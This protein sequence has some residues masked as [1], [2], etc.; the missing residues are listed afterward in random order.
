MDDAVEAFV[1]FVAEAV[2]GYHDP[3]VAE[4]GL[5][6]HPVADPD[7]GLL[8]LVGGGRVDKVAALVFVEVEDLEDGFLVHCS[9]HRSPAYG[10]LVLRIVRGNRS[11]LLLPYQ[12]SPKFIMP[13]ARGL[14]LI[15]AEG[16]SKRYLP[17]IPKADLGSGLACILSM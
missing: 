7:F 2:F 16:A 12:A 6:S 4:A 9:H 10:S 3:L 13:R 8:V 5:G 1:D 17:S 14:I 11:M 15:A